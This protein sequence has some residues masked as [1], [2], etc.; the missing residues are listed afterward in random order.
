MANYD[1]KIDD[2]DK[3]TLYLDDG[4]ELVCD[5]LGIF[6]GGENEYVAL[7]PEDADE[8]AE[9]FLYRF[10]LEDDDFE[11]IKLEN[12][13]SDAEFELASKAYEEYMNTLEMLNEEE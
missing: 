5:V 6:N 10:I 9:I 3:M 11:N 1:N 13:E 12:I 7:L 2:N 4:T 8:N